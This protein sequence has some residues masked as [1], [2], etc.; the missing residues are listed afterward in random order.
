MKEKLV[1]IIIFVLLFT[2]LMPNFIYATDFEVN[3][4]NFDEVQN[5]YSEGSFNKLIN[6]AKA[7][8]TTRS[9]K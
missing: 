5:S 1:G 8:I 4:S 9:R 6:E 7:D 2:T 3:S